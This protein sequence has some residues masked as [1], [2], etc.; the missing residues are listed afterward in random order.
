MIQPVSPFTERAN[1]A[2]R[3]A[4]SFRLALTVTALILVA[5]GFWLIA[6]PAWVPVAIAAERVHLALWLLFAGVVTLLVRA[7]MGD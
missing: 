1:A 6:V 3:R 7:A 5:S 2:A 4:R